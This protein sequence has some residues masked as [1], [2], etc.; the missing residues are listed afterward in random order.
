LKKIDNNV[1]QIFSNGI[2]GMKELYL[3]WEKLR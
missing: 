2:N 3:F 1:L